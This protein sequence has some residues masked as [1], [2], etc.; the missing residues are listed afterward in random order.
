MQGHSMD[1]L[2]KYLE[3]DKLSDDL[4][5]CKRIQTTENLNCLIESLFYRI[6]PKHQGAPQLVIP[7]ELIE[8][9]LTAH[10]DDPFAG[11]FGHVISQLY[12]WKNMFSDVKLHCR[13]GFKCAIHKSANPRNKTSLRTKPVQGPFDH[14]SVDIMGPMTM[15]VNGNKY[16]VV[17]TDYLTKYSEACALSDFKAKMVA[18]VFV[19][20]IILKHICPTVLQSDQATNFTSELIRQICKLCNTGKK[21]TTPYHPI[22]NSEVECQNCTLATILSIYVNK[23]HTDWDKY[24]PYAVF[25]YNNPKQDS[26]KYSPF[27]LLHGRECHYPQM[28]P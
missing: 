20:K 5:E 27:F 23:Q 17:F 22:A 3:S 18:R 9:I 14:V 26:T 19:E 12:Y 6:Y 7:I 13:A 21:F 8:T 24:V 15:T 10:H 16:I 25:A 2:I 1:L 28:L 4:N 11:H